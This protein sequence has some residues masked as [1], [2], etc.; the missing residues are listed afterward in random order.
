MNW[1]FLLGKKAAT[2]QGDILTELAE[3]MQKCQLEGAKPLLFT[4]C[5]EAFYQLKEKSEKYT[6]GMFGAEYHENL[7]TVKSVF[8]VPV[9]Y[10]KDMKERA[11]VTALFM[12]EVKTFSR[13]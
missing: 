5:P 3:L 6:H 8:G 13:G 11:S 7:T 4:L 1:H 2:P 10:C 9:G 12:D